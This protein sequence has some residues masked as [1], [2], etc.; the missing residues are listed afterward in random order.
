MR[1]FTLLSKIVLLAAFLLL[2]HLPVSLTAGEFKVSLKRETLSVTAEK[3]PLQT[4]LLELT[5]DG[6]TVR[7]DPRINPLIT[8][9]FKGRP[10]NQA[11]ETILKPA[12]YSLLWESRPDISENNAIRLAEIQV[13][14]SGRNDQMKPLVLKR[15][16]EIIKNSTGVFYV[17]DELLLYLPLDTDLQKLEKLLL[18]YNAI[19]DSSSI[20]LPGPVKI[21]LPPN[22]D[23][24]AIAREIKKRL[25]IDISQPNY[26]YPLDPPVVHQTG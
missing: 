13:F 10:I 15:V 5:R 24:F 17:K 9:N 20:R 22:S 6:V 2:C 26:A 18:T 11:L 16:A 19:L 14:Q 12:S 3:V 21:Q 8:V 7:I 1:K 23:V 4:I 25:N